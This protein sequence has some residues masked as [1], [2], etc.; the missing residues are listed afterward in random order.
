MENRGRKR[1]SPWKAGIAVV[2]LLLLGTSACTPAPPTEDP[3][4]AN[5]PD[6][7]GYDRP[8][9][10]SVATTR[11]TVPVTDEGPRSPGTLSCL[12]HR[13]ATD[14]AP[15]PGRF[16]GIFYQFAP[17]GLAQAPLRPD[18]EEEYLAEHGYNVLHC[19]I[20]GTG[21]SAGH[22][23][24]L[25]WP[26]QDIAARDAID[27]LGSQEWSTGK[28]GASGRSYGG[29]TALRAASERPE[30]LAAV[31]TNVAPSNMYEQFFYPGGNLA[32]ADVAWPG[33][34]TSSDPGYAARQVKTWRAHPKEDAYW[35]DLDL[36]GRMQRVEVPVMSTGGW[37][38]VFRAGPVENHADLVRAGRAD[39][40]YL[41]MGPWAHGQAHLQGEQPLPL[42]GQLAWWD[43]WLSDDA[44]GRL[45]EQHIS[46]FAMPTTG[47]P[48]WESYDTWP[49]TTTSTVFPAAGGVL[50]DEAA[51]AS[52]VGFDVDTT[53]GHSTTCL[54]RCTTPETSPSPASDLPGTAGIAGFTAEPVEEPLHLLGRVR[55]RLSITSHATAAHP[56]AVRVLDVGPDGRTMEAAAGWTRVDA[57]ALGRRTHH[58][59]ELQATD[60]IVP[61]GHRIRIAVSAGDSPKLASPDVHG[62]VTVHTGPNGSRFELPVVP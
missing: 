21:A 13:P 28:V 52:S 35:A 41:V 23:Y 6:W 43:H 61:P 45:P 2:L 14:G 40:S 60:W 27:W 16:P 50:R 19:D 3:A 8:A 11:I 7:F 12:L 10:Y 39:T 31:L 47:S 1:R 54:L 59:V 62:T 46:S 32:G 26:V 48:G 24:D 42:G 57:D 17:Y 44:A 37:Y 34:V 18:N 38:D 9:E 30:H 5:Q 56:L 51:P 22:G 25:D 36:S 20:P 4:A 49:R 53:V 15:A 58:T 29:W 33:A 55:A